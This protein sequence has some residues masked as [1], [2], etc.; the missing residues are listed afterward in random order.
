MPN[1]NNNP[2]VQATPAGSG[3]LS[4]QVARVRAV[5][6]EM[7]DRAEALLGRD[8]VENGVCAGERYEAEVE[9][10]LALRVLSALNGVQSRFSATPAEIDRYLR[11]ILAED[12][13]LRY[14]QTIGNLA[15]EEAAKDL[16]IEHAGASVGTKEGVRHIAWLD[17]ADHID[18]AKGGGHYPSRL[19]CSRHSGFGPCPGA[20]QC[21]P[22]S[23]G[24][25]E[26]DDA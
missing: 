15:V 1:D 25:Q 2:P 20:P 3:T 10:G 8:P 22:R 7:K 17:A 19:L 5:A 21:T 18:P 12:T 26:D 24:A 11:Q 16:R 9:L 14:Q 4:E 6:T 13:Y 23:D